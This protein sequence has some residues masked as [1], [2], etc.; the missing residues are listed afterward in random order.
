MALEDILRALEEQAAEQEKEILAEAETMADSTRNDGVRTAERIYTAE[1]ERILKPLKGEQARILNE[2][3]LYQQNEIQS[4]KSQLWLEA[5]EAARSK[6]SEASSGKEYDAAL[7]ILIS[8]ALP[9]MNH[10]VVVVVRPADVKTAK[11]ALKESGRKDATVEED[12]E[13][14]GGASVTSPAT[15]TRTINTLDARL[16]RFATRHGSELATR[17][18]TETTEGDE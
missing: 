6:L 12:P 5:V 7:R 15:S 1:H 14:I 4:R 17:L 13:C 8:E 3:R 18:F 10:D 16:E 11:A 2:A 9:E